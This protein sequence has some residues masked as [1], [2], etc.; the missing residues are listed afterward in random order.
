MHGPMQLLRN[1]HLSR[2]HA[3]GQLT[4]AVRRRPYSVILFDEV[5]KAHADVFN[6]L[7]QVLD[8]GRITDSQG[9]VVSFKNSIIIMTSNLGSTYLLEENKDTAR[10]NVMAAVRAHFR[11]E[12]INRIDE[13]VLF[14]ALNKEQIK[15]IVRIQAARVAKRL[16]DKKM[17]LDLR[18]SAVDFLANKGFDPV[19][20]ARPVKRAVQRDLETVLAKA[21]LRGEFNEGDTVVVEADD[22]GLV[23]S[24]GQVQNS[25]ASGDAMQAAGVA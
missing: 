13:F 8:D 5:E 17:T 6:L 15:G 21:M 20:G 24:R 2:A 18:D 14:D 1:A 10:D 23:L 11:P 9:R 19:Y 4:E 22:R 16:V 3:G 12:F 25:L 7:L